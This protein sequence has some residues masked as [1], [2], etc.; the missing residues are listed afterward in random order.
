MLVPEQKPELLL[1]RDLGE[2]LVASTFILCFIPEQSI[3]DHRRS[4]ARDSRKTQKLR[5]LFTKDVV[6]ANGRQSRKL[7]P[8]RSSSIRLTFFDR[9][10]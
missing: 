2:T 5:R 3:A 6:A 7:R 4:A 10:I 8:A 1:I 9:R